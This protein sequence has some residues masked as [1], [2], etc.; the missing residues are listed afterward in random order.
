MKSKGTGSF[1]VLTGL[2]VLFTP[3]HPGLDR[4]GEHQQHCDVI[5]RTQ[6]RKQDEIEGNCRFSLSRWSR[7]PVWAEVLHRS[8]QDGREHEQHGVVRTRFPLWNREERATVMRSSGLNQP[9]EPDRLASV[10]WREGDRR[11]NEERGE[12][13]EKLSQFRESLLRNGSSFKK[14]RW[15]NLPARENN[16]KNASSFFAD[17]KIFQ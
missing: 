12:D 10:H 11:F 13:L 17:P 9:V 14:F 2:E 1:H 8:R 6:P 16:P 5:T 4:M 7:S 15:D 3:N